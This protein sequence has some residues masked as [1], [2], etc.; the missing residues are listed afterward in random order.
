[1]ALRSELNPYRAVAAACAFVLL[2]AA[3]L[4]AR[5]TESDKA[6]AKPTPPFAVKP[7]TTTTTSTP[8]TQAT[9]TSTA[10]KTTTAPTTTT[11][12]TTTTA[13]PAARATTASTPESM[14]DAKRAAAKRRQLPPVMTTANAANIKQPYPW[15]GAKPASPATKTTASAPFKDVKTGNAVQ[16]PGYAMTVTA[17][18]KAAP[19]RSAPVMAAKP[20]LP[21]TTGM[22]KPATTTTTSSASFKDRMA[23]TTVTPPVMASGAKASNVAPVKATAP[24]AATPAAP[25][26]AAAPAKPKSPPPGAKPDWTFRQVVATSSSSAKLAGGVSLATKPTAQWTKD[27]PA[28]VTT[29]TKTPVTATATTKMP[30]TTTTKTVT[31]TATTSTKPGAAFKGVQA[32][33]TTMAAATAAK[34]PASMQNPKAARAGAPLT[35]SVQSLG[36]RFMEQREQYV[37]NSLNRRDPF[38]SLVSGSFEGE[39]GT[40]LLDVSSMKLVGIVWGAS[41]KF[42]LV[43][44]GHGHGFVLRVGDPVLNGY[45]AGLTKQELIVKQSSYGDTQTV[46]IQ[47]QRKEGASNAQ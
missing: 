25:K 37:Y 2:C 47:L 12:A 44:D 24:T 40:P 36:A 32:G 3:P 43:E 7:A 9:K 8:T 39:V 46:T 29:T 1:M 21:S 20:G 11:K 4:G 27:Q 16:S 19:A 23:R 45:I 35:T 28:T 33:S 30:G 26:L 17:P 13:K 42:A 41:D 22:T 15:T 14:A 38:A 10:T 34:A 18:R 5:A 31:A 6:Q